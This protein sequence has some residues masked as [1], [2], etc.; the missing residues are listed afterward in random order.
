MTKCS[1]GKKNIS[2]LNQ[3][4]SVACVSLK[5]KYLKELFGQIV[6]VDIYVCIKFSIEKK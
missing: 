5:K 2:K 3:A 1:L 6:C 4:K